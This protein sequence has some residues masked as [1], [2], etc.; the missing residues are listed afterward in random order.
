MER[1][2]SKALTGLA[3]LALASGVLVA[4]GPAGSAA[5]VACGSSCISLASQSLGPGDVGAVYKGTAAVASSFRPAR[6]RS[7]QMT[8][9]AL[10]KQRSPTTSRRFTP[11]SK[12]CGSHG[13]E[14]C[15][16]NAYRTRRSGR[17]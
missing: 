11:L 12:P 17:L 1:V 9:R 2:K 6:K 13:P 3:A 14:P 4:M 5:T 7:S 8:A 16:L 10:L 15:D